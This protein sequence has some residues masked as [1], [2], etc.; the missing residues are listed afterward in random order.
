MA[1]KVFISYHH[2]LDQ[3]YRDEFESIFTGS[4]RI[5]I[6]KSV[7][8]GDID[9]NL[10]DQAIAQKI[11]DEYLAD[12]TVTIV[13]LGRST[14]GRMHVDWEIDSSL[15]ETKLSSR[16]GLLGILLPTHLNYGSNKYN[17]EFIPG[18]LADNLKNGYAKIYNYSRDPNSVASWIDK[19][20]LD[21]NDK[22][23]DLS[24]PRLKQNLN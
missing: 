6:S 4:S 22:K 24:R 2:A 1:H 19:A 21:R 10:S 14:W 5:L 7:L 17:E 16:S 11:R 13:L 15:R 18:R 23:P 20:F 9:S 8:I 3:N 12:S